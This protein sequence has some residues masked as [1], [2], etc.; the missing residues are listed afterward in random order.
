MRT[1]RSESATVAILAATARAPRLATIDPATIGRTRAAIRRH[2]AKRYALALVAI[3]GAALVVGALP[4]ALY[5]T[6][7]Y[8]PYAGAAVA[9]VA[10]ALGGRAIMAGR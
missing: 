4:L 10:F 6:G 7:V 2:R 1:I 5:V 8:G 3:A 9:L